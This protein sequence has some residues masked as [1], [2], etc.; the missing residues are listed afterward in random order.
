[1][2]AMLHT[3]Q[4]VKLIFYRPEHL[5][6][7]Q[8]FQL[9]KEQEKFTA[10]PIEMLEVATEGQYRIVIEHG[11]NAVGFFLLHAMERVKEYSKNPHAMLLT[12]LS[13]DYAQQGRGFAKQGMKKLDQFV[14]E[15]FPSCNEIV[16][17]VNYRNVAAQQL[18]EKV[19]FIDTGRRKEG[20][21][22]EQ[23]IMSYLI[24]VDRCR[25]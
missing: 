10:L 6:S 21:R 18:Y 17:A 16:L 9:P 11:S 7:L 3:S 8:Q 15:N 22:G 5:A 20:P 2:T 24:T 14:E 4:D 12:A 23:W 25:R 13:I 1:M 19:G